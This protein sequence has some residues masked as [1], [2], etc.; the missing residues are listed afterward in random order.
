MIKNFLKIALRSLLKHKSSTIIN[1]TGLSIGLAATIMILMWIQQELSF[2]KFYTDSELLYRVEQDQSYGEGDPYHVNVTPVPAGPVWKRDIA[3]ITDA[4]RMMRLPRLLFEKDDLKIYES[5]VAG[6]DSTFFRMFDLNFIYGEPVTALN[7]PHSIVITEE[8]A[9]KYFGDENPIGKPITLEKQGEFIVTGVLEKIPDNTIL[10]FDAVIPFEFLYEIGVAN[11]DSWGSNSIVTYVKLV[12]NANLDE[13]GQKISDVRRE[14]NERSTAVFMVN[15]VSRVRL[16]GYFGYAKPVGAIIYIYIFGAISLFVLVIACINFINLSTA[17]SANRS[18]E[19]GIKKVSGAL[20]RSI[21]T[22]FLVESVLQV[23]IALVVALILV[24]LLIN[25]FNTISGK[26][27]EVSDLFK[28]EYIIGYIVLALFTGILAGLYPSFYLASFKP[29]DVLKGERSGGS[30]SGRL[31]KILVVVQFVLSIFLATS[32]LVIYSQ[33]K[34]MREIDMGYDKDNIVRI[35]MSENMAASYQ[36]LKDELERHPLIDG[37][38]AT[39]GA[40]H[41]MGSNSGGVD[42]EGK[43]PEQSVLIGFNGIDYGYT[44]TMGI[45]MKY[46]RGFTKDYE[47]DMV[48]DSTGNFI[49]N[50]EVARIIGKENPVGMRFD[51]V[52]FSGT[53]V[54]VMEDFYFKPASEVIEP[55][56]F[57]CAPL[58]FLQHIVIKINPGNR[59]EALEALDEIWAKVIPDYPLDYSFVADEVDRLYRSETRMGNLFKYFTFLAILLASLGLYGLSSFIAEQRTREIGVRKVMGASIGNVVGR[60]T[61]EFLILV[62]LA[63]IV[64]LPLS[65]FYMNKW[66]NDFPYKEGMDVMLFALV[67]AGSLSIAAIAVSFQSFKAGRTNPADTLRIE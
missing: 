23:F 33:V 8:L 32:G 40:P 54:G 47:G 46:G 37:V 7:E 17:R 6:A 41:N 2:D 53:I 51:F 38:S 57:I 62:S 20:R 43:D 50:E 12:N 67:A 35:S 4:T 58:S 44:S 64:G 18:K 34:Y 63:L 65:W 29:L 55:M 30:K 48:A 3:E 45:N 39:M 14:H 56:A 61:R 1:I 21:R 49:I 52:G 26:S 15:P 66:L 42:W 27:F 9:I 22:Q 31:R 36:V 19:I 10:S 28:L 59:K 11:D 5:G 16:H 13:V 25:V 60:L 24:G